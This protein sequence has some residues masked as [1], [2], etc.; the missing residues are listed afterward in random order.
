MLGGLLVP[1]WLEG[2][3]TVSDGS[4]PLY[5]FYFS[6]QAVVTYVTSKPNPNLLPN[7]NEIK[8]EGKVTTTIKGQSILGFVIDWKPDPQTHVATKETLIL[9]PTITTTLMMS[10]WNLKSNKIATLPVNKGV[11]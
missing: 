3:W 9:P 5:Y 7:P 6:S 10:N 1:P 4:K 2:W 11:S 8:N